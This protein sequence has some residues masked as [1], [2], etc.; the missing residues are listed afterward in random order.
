MKIIMLDTL[1]KIA[2][3]TDAK[4]EKVSRGQVIRS[5]RPADLVLAYLQNL[6][7]QKQLRDGR[8]LHHK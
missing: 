8:Y 1:R 5:I 6:M 3:K 2:R 7:Q 4:Y